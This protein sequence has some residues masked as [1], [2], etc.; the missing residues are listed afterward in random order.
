MYNYIQSDARWGGKAYAGENMAVAGCG[1]TSVADVTGVQPPTV[2]D[3]IT[4]IGGAS[5]GSGT[6]WW[7][8]PVACKHFGMPAQQLNS[9]SVYGVYGSSAE[10]EWLAKMK[11][12][13]YYGILLMGC[14]FF[15]NGGHYIAVDRVNANNDVTVYDVAYS[16]RSGTYNWFATVPAGQ[17]G[18][19]HT[20]VPFF[21]GRVK[22]FY[23]IEK[24]QAKKDAIAVDGMWGPATTKLAQRIYKSG[25][26][27]GIVSNQNKA[28]R[29]HLAMCQ[30]ASW[31]FVPQAD[32]KNGSALVKAL[33]K[34][35]GV[36]QDGFMGIETIKAFQKW[37][38]VEVD[39]YLGTETV[40]AFQRRLNENA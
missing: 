29:S 17:P 25:T 36:K 11:T 33:Q 14:G 31:E 16:L 39:G 9:G 18:A 37:L 35:L 22:I 20:G 2:A 4:A 3:Y 28:M 24:P 7:A 26:I 40:K 12:G 32:L 34:G 13:K 1:P 10:A 6:E 8:I 5:N 27:D 19:C 30:P 21:R 38:G 23:L 15:C